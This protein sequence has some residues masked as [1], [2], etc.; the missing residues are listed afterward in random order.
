MNMN[1]TIS[2]IKFAIIGW[3]PAPLIALAALMPASGTLF[4]ADAAG[5]V[6]NPA[7]LG[8]PWALL[9]TGLT[10]FI[11]AGVKTLLPRIQAKLLP[12]LAGL[13][14]L[15]LTLPSQYLAGINVNWWQGLL[16]GLGGVGLREL[17]SQLA[18]ALP[19]A[20]AQGKV[21]PDAKDG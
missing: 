2:S 4:A 3:R 10:P 20:A 19:G 5:A 9:I 1:K 11:I 15:A 7:A 14:G 16:L 13:V 8:D 12:A 18:G 17:Y 21:A 6:G